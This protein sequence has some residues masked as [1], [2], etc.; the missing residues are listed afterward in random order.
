MPLCRWGAEFCDSHSWRF[1]CVLALQVCQLTSFSRILAANPG[2]NVYD[3]TKTCD[4]P[5]CYDM[6]TADNFLNRP[7]VRQ[8]LGVGNRRWEE[9]NMAVNSDF[10]GGWVLG[11]RAPNNV[12]FQ[13]SL[14][15]PAADSV[16]V[17]I[18]AQ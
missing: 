14:N 1:A 5:L 9:C 10:M 12:L 6:S 11:Y 13:Q 7:D 3:I 2:I 4:G 8:E 15:P 17:R 16:S 18:A